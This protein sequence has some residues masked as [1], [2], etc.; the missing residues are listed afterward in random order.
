[1]EDIEIL[2][3]LLKIK[4]TNGNNAKESLLKEYDNNDFKKTLKYLYDTQIVFGLSDKKI[5]KKIN[6]VELI[7]DFSNILDAFEYLEQHNTG[8]DFDVF[9][10]QHFIEKFDEKHHSMLKEMFAKKLKIGVTEGTL[11]KVYP[12]MFVKYEVM[13]GEPYDKRFEKIEQEMPN[14]VLTQKLDGMRLTVR[15][16][17]GIVKC[18]ARSGKLVTG[19]KDLE[20]ELSTLPDGAYDGELL[21]LIDGTIAD[22]SKMPKSSICH[23]LYCPKNAEE[24]YSDTLSIASSKEEDKKDLGL[25]LF[26]MVPLKNFDKKEKYDVPTTIRKSKLELVLS[27]K[28]YKYIKNVPVLYEGK[29][30]TDLIDSMLNVAV[31][32]EQEGLM[33]NYADAGYEFKRT[34]SLIKIKQI[35][36]AD[37]RVKGFEEGTG[38]NKGK[39]GAF[40]IETPQGVEIKVG[41]GISDEIREDVWKKQAGFIGCIMEIAFTTPSTNK[42]D[43]RYSLRFPRFKRWRTDKTEENWE[44]F[45]EIIEQLEAKKEKK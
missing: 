9:A 43:D 42:D 33:M 6:N 29:F 27:M 1:M 5:N 3:A 4:D 24:L 20:E 41:S 35:Y 44:E 15:V 40:I 11:A 34:N 45:D 22:I 37:V 31:K 25:F 23:K 32:L 17:N 8:T 18:F 30:N 39:L 12:D 7:K 16:E 14:I 10:V 26:D 38:K 13:A 19:L 21:K 36:T 2:D 28:N